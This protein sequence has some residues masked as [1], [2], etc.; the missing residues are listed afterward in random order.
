LR[1]E[2][3]PR[4]PTGGCF[5]VYAQACLCFRGPVPMIPVNVTNVD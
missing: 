3:R 5:L 2:W 1:P 4:V